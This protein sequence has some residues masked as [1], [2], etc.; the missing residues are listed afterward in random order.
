MDKKID[1]P[2]LLLHSCCAPCST[3]VI[4]KLVPDFDITVLYYN[5]NIYPKEEYILRKNEQKK[6][7]NILNINL[8]EDEYEP[9]EYCK[10]MKSFE[11]QKE[12]EHRCY[13]CYKLRLT[14]TFE[15]AKALNYKF[16]TTTLSVSPQKNAK[17]INEIGLKLEN[18]HCKFLV[19]DFKKQ[20]GYKHSIELSKKYDLYR[21]N[22]CGCK[23]SIRE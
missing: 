12:G 2:K 8:I 16:F 5:P 6:L 1:K 17:W 13:E 22:Y 23:N 11:N 4:E 20:D 7:L 9:E 14:R 21:Q 3:T 19:R 18:E 10:N 15:K